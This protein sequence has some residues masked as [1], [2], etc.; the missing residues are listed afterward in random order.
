MRQQY[1]CHLQGTAL[2]RPSHQIPMSP[3]VAAWRHTSAYMFAF[4]HQKQK[5]K[6]KRDTATKKRKHTD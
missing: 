4:E 5:K 2:Y 3:E 1:A 6:A